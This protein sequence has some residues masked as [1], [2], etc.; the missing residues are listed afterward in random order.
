MS[1]QMW[2]IA[3]CMFGKLFQ[4]QIVGRKIGIQ[5]LQNC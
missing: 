1:A 3:V 2:I 5:M 4:M